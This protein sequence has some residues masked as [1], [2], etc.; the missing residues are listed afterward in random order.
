MLADEGLIERAARLGPRVLEAIQAIESPVVRDVRGRGLLIGVELTGAARPY[1][2]RLLARGVLCKETHEHVIRI[3]P[4][5]VT[6][7]ADLDWMVEQLRA[8]LT[9]G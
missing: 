5:L 3:A 9:T 2:E 6:E 8:A 7:E 4:P 1:C